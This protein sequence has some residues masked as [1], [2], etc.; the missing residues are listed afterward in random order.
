MASRLTLIRNT[1]EVL[2]ERKNY[3]GVEMIARSP[4]TGNYHFYRFSKNGNEVS[5][6]SEGYTRMAGLLNAL[7]LEEDLIE[8]FAAKKN[9]NRAYAYFKSVIS[10]KK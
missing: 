9:P 5:G 7:K 3:I 1:F 8:S 2:H 10:K 4:V 6:T